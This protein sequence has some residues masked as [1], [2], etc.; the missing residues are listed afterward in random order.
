MDLQ[1]AV[2]R[3]EGNGLVRRSFFDNLLDAMGLSGN[4]DE[5]KEDAKK[6]TENAAVAESPAVA[7]AV[8][9]ETVTETTTM[10]MTVTVGAA[11]VESVN[12]TSPETVAVQPPAKATAGVVEGVVQG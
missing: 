12:A 1:A 5:S 11:P 2:L 4:K 6:V 9:P 7:A 10:M 8:A 3:E